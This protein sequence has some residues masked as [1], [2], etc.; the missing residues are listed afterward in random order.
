M[1]KLKEIKI[2]LIVLGEG[3][4]KT[5]I[6][7]VI[8]EKKLEQRFYFLG[9][10]PP[11]DM[12]KYFACADALLITLK[13]A[14]IFSYTLPGKLQSYLACGKPI[15]G[16]LDGIG[17][18]IIEESNS[19]FCTDAENSTELSKLFLKLSRLPKENID[20]FS[21]NALSYFKD[22]FAKDKLLLDLE[23]IFNA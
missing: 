5:R 21:K 4:D 9:S 12:S 2:N 17:K 19:G 8:K 16:A 15:V 18:K 7:K 1:T 6:Q 10:Y 3:R 22:N 11:D 20:K 14:E 23:N 13:K